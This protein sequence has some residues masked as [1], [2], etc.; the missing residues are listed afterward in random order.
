MLERCLSLQR[1]EA[2]FGQATAR[3]WSRASDIPGAV[4]SSG[5][6]SVFSFVVPFDKW[7]KPDS[8]DDKGVPLR[9]RCSNLGMQSRFLKLALGRPLQR[10]E[11]RLKASSRSKSLRESVE[12]VLRHRTCAIEETI[13]ATSSAELCRGE[14]ESWIENVMDMVCRVFDEIMETSS[15]TKTWLPRITNTFNAQK[16][17]PNATTSYVLEDVAVVSE[18]GRKGDDARLQTDGLGDR[19]SGIVVGVLNP[20]MGSG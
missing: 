18:P 13:A 11:L 16:G 8:R 19:T 3:T 10:L 17:F 2:R 12:R 5:R 20:L 14:G 6:K 9:S 1:N 4:A 7:L 15:S